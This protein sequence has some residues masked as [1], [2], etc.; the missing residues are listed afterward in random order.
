MST[1]VNCT[2]L[3]L[4]YSFLGRVNGDSVNQ[5]EGQV[6]VFERASLTLNCSY[7]TKQY[8]NL[9]WY[10]QYPGES[11]QLLL[12]AMKA[13]DQGRN[14][15]FEATYVTETSS[16]HLKKASVQQSDSAVYYCA[17]RDTVAGTA[18]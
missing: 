9:F 4:P 8:P 12:K 18:G 14:K 17:L 7:E 10:V 6:T 1:K 5:T 16:F 11:L 15:G 13:N 2:E 3:I